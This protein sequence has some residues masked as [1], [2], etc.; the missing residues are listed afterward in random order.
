MRLAD[1]RRFKDLPD[2]DIREI[3][4]DWLRLAKQRKGGS[5]FLSYRR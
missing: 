3:V 2:A 5:A 1:N 4:V